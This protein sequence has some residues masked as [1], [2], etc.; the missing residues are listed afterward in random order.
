MPCQQTSK[1]QQPKRMKASIASAIVLALLVTLLPSRAEAKW[2]QQSLP[3]TVPTAAV[4]GA[5]A[6]GAAVIGLLI[7][8]KLRHKG[9]A[10]V[11]LDA[12]PARFDDA[13]PGQ[14]VEKSV[15]VVNLM[16]DPITVKSLAVED[17]THAF[18]LSDARKVPFTIAPGERVAIPLVLS[19]SNGSGKARLR[20]VASAPGLEKDATK[21]VS[22]SYGRQASRL[23]KLVH[24]R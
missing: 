11:K 23:A 13:P 9:A 8:L 16:N 1:N 3:G 18:T 2:Q 12:P 5:V 14:P 4:V 7:Y 19:A 21:F 22:I 17:P 20:I 15:P 10:H 6:A 24:A